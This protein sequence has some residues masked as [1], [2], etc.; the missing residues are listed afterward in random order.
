DALMREWFEL[1]TDRPADEVARLTNPEQ[2]HPMQAKQ[3]LGRDIVTFYHGAP[4]AEEAAAEWQR[5]FSERQDPSE[6]AERT[7]PAAE[8]ADGRIWVCKLLVLLDLAKSNN[9]ARRSVQG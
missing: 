9:E 5:R 7:I 6:I 1:L 4:A 8:L 3:T 2:M